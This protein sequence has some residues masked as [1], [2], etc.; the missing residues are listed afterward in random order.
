MRPRVNHRLD[1]KDHA[2]TQ[3][4]TPMTKP[5]V[6]N[7]RALMHI[8]T[9][10]MASIIAYNAKARPFGNALDGMTDIA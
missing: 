5:M 9:N 1:S 10:A 4:E 6:G 2:Y 3:R 8:A 7:M